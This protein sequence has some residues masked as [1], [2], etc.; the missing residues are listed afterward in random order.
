MTWFIVKLIFQIKNSSLAAQFDEQYRLVLGNDQSEAFQ[1]ACL[2]AQTEEENFSTLDNQT[3]SWCFV[4]ISSIYPMERLNDGIELFS[5]IVETNEM[6]DYLEIVKIK[7]Q[8]FSVESR[9][10]S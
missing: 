3:I 6:H 2:L 9:L 5:N 1:K 10:S 4:G 7:H 8:S